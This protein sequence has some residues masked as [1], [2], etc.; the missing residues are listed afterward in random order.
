MNPGSTY[1]IVDEVGELALDLEVLVV[2][3]GAQALVALRAVLRA[4]RVRIESERLLVRAGGAGSVIAGSLSPDRCRPTLEHF[5]AQFKR[6]RFLG[7]LANA[8]GG[9]VRVL[10]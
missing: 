4:Q 9:A 6:S 3:V 7:G 2:A 1:G 5:R 8:M 10:P